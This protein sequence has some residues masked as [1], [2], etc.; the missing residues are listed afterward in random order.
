MLR[1]CKSNRYKDA[2]FRRRGRRGSASGEIRRRGR[3]SGVKN[4][5]PSGQPEIP[6]NRRALDNEIKEVEGTQKVVCAQLELVP[7][8]I[9]DE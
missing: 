7:V 4:W 1:R 6:M 9:Y 5:T 2:K 3:K 8:A